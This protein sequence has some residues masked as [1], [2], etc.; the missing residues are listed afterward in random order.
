ME[1]T[2]TAQFLVR[3]LQSGIG[4]PSK[5]IDPGFIQ[6]KTECRIEFSEFD[7]QRQADI[8][9]ADNTESYLR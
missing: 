2:C 5:F 6:I 4:A 8:S 7:G 3:D 1:Q 9:E